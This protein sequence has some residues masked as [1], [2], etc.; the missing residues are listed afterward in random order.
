MPCEKGGQALTKP[1]EEEYDLLA[2]VGQVSK[3]V[4]QYASKSAYLFDLLG[5]P[6]YSEFDSK[7]LR[8]IARLSPFAP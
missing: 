5:N 8:K 4:V 7:R 6:S 3:P 1:T 2:E